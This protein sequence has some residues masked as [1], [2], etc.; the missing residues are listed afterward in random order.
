MD[1][2]EMGVYQMSELGELEKVWVGRR[3]QWIKGGR[4]GGS[5]LDDR[6]YLHSGLVVAIVPKGNSAIPIVKKLGTSKCQDIS[7]RFDRAIILRDK[8]SKYGT[9]ATP[10]IGSLHVLR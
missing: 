10:H 6:Q 8:P 4:R 1:R 3:V 5:H 9:L 7:T 2:A